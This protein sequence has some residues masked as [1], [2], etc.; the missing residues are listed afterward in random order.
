MRGSDK[1]Y[2]AVAIVSSLLLLILLG[3]LAYKN[4]NLV[5]RLLNSQNKRP[6]AEGVSGSDK[7]LTVPEL[8]KRIKPSVVEITTYDASDHP[9]A[10]GSGF[11]TGPQRLLSN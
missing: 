2:R 11:F 3:F 5:R 8:V 7:Q 6:A 1:A 9:D 4:P 10:I